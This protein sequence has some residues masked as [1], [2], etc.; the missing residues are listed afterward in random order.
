MGKCPTVIPD[1][2]ACNPSDPTTSCDTF[3]GFASCHNGTC[4][5]EGSQVCK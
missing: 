1:G 2:Q 4:V 5:L 3:A